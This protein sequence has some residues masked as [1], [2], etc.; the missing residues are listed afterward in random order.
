M[1]LRSCTILL[2]KNSSPSSKKPVSDS[3]MPA[4]TESLRNVYDARGLFCAVG[5]CVVTLMCQTLLA[6]AN[7]PS[8]ASEKPDS[9]AE[10]TGFT[11]ITRR[12]PNARSSTASETS[13]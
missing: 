6:D 7:R 8:Y 9:L 1:L 4:M 3:M 13:C 2:V 10:K 11:R 12:P 5:T